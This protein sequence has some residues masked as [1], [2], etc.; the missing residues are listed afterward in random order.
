M[1]LKLTRPLVV[2]DVET[3][4]LDPET[5]RIVQLAAV[6]LEPDGSRLPGEWLIN[7]GVPCSAEAEQVHGFTAE[8]LGAAPRWHEV[9]PAI[10]AFFDGAD[11]GG[12]NVARFDL[13]FLRKEL[14]RVDLALGQHCV[15]DVMALYHK[16]Q[17]R[18]LEAA[19]KH[20]CG[21]EL[22]DAHDA[23]ADAA[24]T[25]EVLEALLVRHQYVPDDPAGLAAFGV[26]EGAVDPDGKLLRRS[27]GAI[28]VNFSRNHKGKPLTEV[29]GG[30]LEWMM[31]KDFT[32]EVLEHIG[33][34][35]KRRR[36]GAAP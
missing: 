3:T 6:R 35:L 33:G 11:I 17:P 27:D 24:A 20:Y 34:E 30:F 21:R 25:I 4:G 1:N 10:H 18:N 31:S 32:P 8:K 36:S 9:A 16:L 29:D 19:Y 14:A 22:K 13:P 2:F 23:A 12:F 26:P 7:P 28:I 15:V 5:D